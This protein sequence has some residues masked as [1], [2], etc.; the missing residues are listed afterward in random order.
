M[1]FIIRD[2]G[3][4]LAQVNNSFFICSSLRLARLCVAPVPVIIMALALARWGSPL[5]KSA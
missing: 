2:Y 3:I 4:R 1:Q 5:C